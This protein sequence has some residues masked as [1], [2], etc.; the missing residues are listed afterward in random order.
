MASIGQGVVVEAPCAAV[1]DMVAE[2]LLETIYI[3]PVVPGQP[4]NPV[5]AQGS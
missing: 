1:V 4:A 5:V 3:A 2:Q